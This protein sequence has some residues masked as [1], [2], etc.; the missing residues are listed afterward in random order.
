MG[1]TKYL[2][3][4]VGDGYKSTSRTIPGK[5]RIHRTATISKIIK[6]GLVP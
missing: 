2:K 1:I 5:F 3:A 6:V 4:M